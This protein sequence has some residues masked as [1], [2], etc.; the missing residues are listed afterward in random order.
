MS[1]KKDS[2]SIIIKD[3]PA[4][5]YY[6]NLDNIKLHLQSK[7]TGEYICP[8]C[9]TSYFPNLGEKVKRANKFETP[10]GPT[11][12]ILSLV[13]D[14]S[15]T[16]PSTVYKQPKLPPSFEM[17]KRTGVKITDYQTSED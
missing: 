4:G 7:E 15:T 10:S 8:R 12:P 2:T 1:D 5:P 14:N 9:S 11:Q 6:C 13:Q 3:I 17:L 16:E